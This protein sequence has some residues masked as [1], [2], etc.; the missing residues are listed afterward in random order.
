LLYL[1]LNRYIFKVWQKI[2]KSVWGDAISAIAI[3]LC[4]SLDVKQIVSINNASPNA[5]FIVVQ[6]SDKE[7][8]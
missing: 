4:R 2:E 7:Q 3:I 5:N 1:K 8:V 6:D